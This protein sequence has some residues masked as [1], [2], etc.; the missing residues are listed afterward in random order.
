M[1]TVLITEQINEAG[2]RLLEEAGHQL[3]FMETWEMSELSEKIQKA[4]I[5]LVRVLP[6]PGDIIKGAPMLK[7]IS[8]HGV[9]TDNIDMAAAK[10]AGVVVTNTPGANSEAVAEYAFSLLLTLAKTLPYVTARYREIGFAAKNS[11]PAMELEGKTLGI[12]GCGRIGRRVADMAQGFRMKVLG[13]DP[14]L[15]QAPDGIKLTSDITQIYRECDFITLHC[16]LNDETFH[17]IGEE[18]IA[19]MKPTAILANCARGPLVDEVAMVKALQEGRLAGAGLDVTETDPWESGSPLFDMKNV[20][21]TPH[22]AMTTRETEEKCATS[23]AQNIID[24]IEG[25][26]LP[27]RLV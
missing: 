6:L 9:G 16:L 14:F 12:I 5:V 8:K 19:M 10:A 24:F 1:S 26:A 22:F 23:A 25:R 11:K 13:Y 15:K 20:I 7:M 18:E 27:A 17:M 4:D 3:L 2:I 21:L